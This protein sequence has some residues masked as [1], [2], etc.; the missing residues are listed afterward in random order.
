MKEAKVFTTKMLQAIIQQ[1]RAGVPFRKIAAE[2][3]ADPGTIRNM[4]I[5]NNEVPTHMPIYKNSYTIY[6]REGNVVVFGTSK[7]CAEYMG[8]KLNTLYG[9]L[10]RQHYQDLPRTIVKEDFE[11]A[12]Q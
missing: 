11:G 10:S 5:R 9:F 3:G 2:Y 12:L 1:N 4:L 7:E 6:D 8:W